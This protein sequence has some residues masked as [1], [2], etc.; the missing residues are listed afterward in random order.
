M[1]SLTDLAVFICHII[2]ECKSVMLVVAIIVHPLSLLQ[3]V[4]PFK[5]IRTLPIEIRTSEV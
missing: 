5:T 4:Q 1:N 3:G 2:E